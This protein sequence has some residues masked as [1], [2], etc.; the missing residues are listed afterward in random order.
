MNAQILPNGLPP[1]LVKAVEDCEFDYALGLRDG[2]MIRF[3]GASLIDDTEEWIHL[4]LGPRMGDGGIIRRD[5]YG[6]AW[7]F[8]RGLD[9]R[10]SEIAWVADAP[11]GS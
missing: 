11:E 3:I 9:V 10:L 4:D 1:A 2:T 8:E 6:Q 7:C 5:G